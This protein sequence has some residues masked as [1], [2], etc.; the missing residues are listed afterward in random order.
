M[1][2]EEQ[3]LQLNESLTNKLEASKILI[4]EYKDKFGEY[5]AVIAELEREKLESDDSIQ[6]ASR[7]ISE[8]SE[9]GS[10]DE[11]IAK[12]ESYDDAADEIS[13]LKSK[14]ESYVNIG[15][16]E[17]MNTVIGE[18]KAM[19]MESAAVSIANE[20]GIEYD[21]AVMAID[22]FESAAEAKDFL[23]QFITSKSGTE[24]VVEVNHKKTSLQPK[25]ESTKIDG[26]KKYLAQLG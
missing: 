8:L 3:L 1:K 4:N 13:D 10:K 20:L 6:R 7:I 21:K 9:L 14:L 22:K 18:Y 15:T 11:I 16:V 25:V 24:K 5:E 17:Q 23:S 26:L 19:K 12:L 2:T